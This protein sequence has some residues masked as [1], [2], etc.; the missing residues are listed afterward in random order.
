MSSIEFL[1][2]T[3]FMFPRNGL[4]PD[5]VTWNC[6]AHFAG[7]RFRNVSFLVGIEEC[8]KHFNLAT[9]RDDHIEAGDD[10]FRTRGSKSPR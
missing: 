5:A 8:V 6:C 1:R 7:G 9:F 3:A 2:S 10:R 4:F